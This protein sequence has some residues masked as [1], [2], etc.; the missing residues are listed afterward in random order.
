[1]KHVPIKSDIAVKIS[2]IAFN[3]KE[4]KTIEFVTVPILVDITAHQEN[5]GIEFD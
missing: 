1:M 2:D 5:V 4:N 3:G